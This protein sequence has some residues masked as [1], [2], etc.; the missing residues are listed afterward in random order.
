MKLTL[1]PKMHFRFILFVFGIII[2]IYGFIE[3]D[4][5]MNALDNPS[6][7]FM[8]ESPCTNYALDFNGTHDFVEFTNLFP[9]HESGDRTIEFWYLSN[10]YTDQPI[11]HS[12]PFDYGIN[13]NRFN[14]FYSWSSHR[15]INEYR[16]PNPNHGLNY[17]PLGLGQPVNTRVWIHHALVREGNVYRTY[18]NGLLESE[19]TDANPYLPNSM[20]W[21]LSTN[22]QSIDGEIDE[23]RIFNR[24]RS[25]QEIFNNMNLRMNGQEEGLIGLWN[26]DEGSGIYAYDQ[27]SSG[28]PGN[29]GGRGPDSYHYRPDF[30]LSTAPINYLVHWYLDNDGDQHAIHDSLSCSQPGEG[31]T[32]VVLP[33]DDCD[34]QNA[35]VNPGAQELCN[36]HDDN[37]N[38]MTDEGLVFAT[39]YRDQDQDGYGTG[40]GELKCSDPGTGWSSL[41]GD[42]DDTQQG[43][44]P[45]GPDDNC[46]GVDDNCNGLID[47]GALFNTYFLDIDSD[48]HASFSISA[49]TSPGTGYTLSI[50]PIDDCDDNDHTAY[51]GAGEI[52]CNGKDEDCNGEDG[53]CNTCIPGDLDQDGICDDVDNCSSYNPT[54]LDNDCDGVGDPCDKCPGGNDKLDLD[55]NGKSDCAFPPAYSL[56]P[57]SWKCGNNKVMV[58]KVNDDGNQNTICINYNALNAQVRPD[59]LNYCGPCHEKKCVVGVLLPISNDSDGDWKVYPN[60]SGGQFNISLPAT[61]VSLRELIIYDMNGKKVYTKNILD[62][63]LGNKNNS[64]PINGF[65]A[66]LYLIVLKSPDKLE[67]KRIL[68][69]E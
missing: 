38:G 54:Q 51:P 16:D 62:M 36:D 57:N 41:N 65:K 47:E 56:L 7:L 10:L 4:N 1:F 60:P 31:Y 26:F 33:L 29:L 52:P 34:D 18:S 32:S 49:C 35:A 59:K 63:N 68:I 23:V 61:D 2:S 25:Q 21:S 27:S 43:R 50:L 46:D 69:L 45:G 67:A 8:T 17:H 20:G 24:A 28:H 6:G 15:I 53:T 9:F 22:W 14:L 13:S 42:C 5:K 40:P 48:G 66:G 58:C 55:Q 12:Q 64:I 3:P 30:I 19:V 11:V 44:F 37:C 39:Y